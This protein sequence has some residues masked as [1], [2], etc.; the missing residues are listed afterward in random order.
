MN[1]WNRFW[2]ASVSPS[3]LALFR[4]LFA[5]CLWREIRTTRARGV[6]AIADGLFSLPYVDWIPQFSADAYHLIH[7]LQYPIILAIG[8]GLFTRLSCG[9]LFVLQ[10][11][12][13]FA[14]QLS[15]RNHPYFFLLVLL[16]LALSPAGEAFSLTACWRAF[17]ARVPLAERIF[18]EPQPATSQRLI[19]LQ[20][21]LVYF[22][23]GLQKL[24]PTYLSGQV[25]WDKV[26]FELGRDR[27][28]A[29]FE[30]WAP[31]LPE[32]IAGWPWPWQAMAL[33]T[34]ALELGLPIG[35]W[36]ARTRRPC[37]VL[38]LGFHASIAF[39]MDI[40]V[41]SY[42]MMA[43]YLLF[44]KPDAIPRG[45]RAIGGGLKRVVAG[46]RAEAPA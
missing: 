18:G 32:T 33:A 5:Y 6:D 1:G 10:G 34:V 43:T 21:C 22:L 15:F 11:W 8:I 45:L 19:Q 26:A 14:D 36:F 37:I 29:F 16:V 7:D 30:A 25:L 41:F 9:L 39:I 27:S 28:G 13:F 3:S 2:H 12:V 4:V 23:A 17:R 42:A 38:G 40:D 20:V 35:L 31:A 24:H 44:L 46:R